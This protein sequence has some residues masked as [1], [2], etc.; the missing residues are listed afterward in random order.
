VLDS[1][2][3]FLY[4]VLEVVMAALYGKKKPAVIVQF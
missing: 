1:C 4:W 3:T 2:F